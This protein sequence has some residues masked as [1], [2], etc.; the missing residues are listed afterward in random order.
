MKCIKFLLLIAVLSHFNSCVTIH[1]GIPTSSGVLSSPNFK[2]VK[3]NVSGKSTSS[4]FFGIGGNLH[5]GMIAEAKEDLMSTYPL[6]SNQALVNV[7]V[8][9][10]STWF[11]GNFL[12]QT[13][14]CRYTADIVEF[15]ESKEIH[16]LPAPTLVESNQS[17]KTNNNVQSES[18]VKKSDEN[19][20]FQDL[21][22]RDNY[23]ILPNF[24]AVT[25]FKKVSYNVAQKEIN[26]K[27][28]KINNSFL[29][30]I[31]ELKLLYESK[32]LQTLN[33]PLGTYWSAD[34]ES[35]KVKCYNFSNG[36][37]EIKAESEEAYFIPL[38]VLK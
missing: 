38:Y 27:F 37:I 4:Y 9:I 16:Y 28:S 18:V 3:E 35:G 15:V 21:I 5:T 33:L 14:T 2:Y 22:H 12:W 10:Q 1:S 17:S 6:K 20:A 8:D 23:F 7:I 34:T 31:E 19:F 36:K 25:N 29:P 30:T 32:K 11:P 24:M 26:D 13:Y